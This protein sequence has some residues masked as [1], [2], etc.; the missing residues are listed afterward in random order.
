MRVGAPHGHE[1]E[2]GQH[3]E[4]RAGKS[5]T[6]HRTLGSVSRARDENLTRKSALPAATNEVRYPSA[7][8]TT[9][10]AL[11]ASIESSGV[12]TAEST[13]PPR[14]PRSALP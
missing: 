4:A 10:A 6:T 1:R 13:E 14:E 7:S 8:A 3:R 5:E 2:S 11:A 9:D 12:H